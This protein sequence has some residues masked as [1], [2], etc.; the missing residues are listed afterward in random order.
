MRHKRQNHEQI[1]QKLRPAKQL[2][3]RARASPVTAGP[4]KSLHRHTT[5]ECSS[6]GR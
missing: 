4:L 3:P 6:T 5:A 1:M 2:L